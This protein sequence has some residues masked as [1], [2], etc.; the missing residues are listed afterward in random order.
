MPK[1]RKCDLRTRAAILRGSARLLLESIARKKWYTPQP[2]LDPARQEIP[3]PIRR[4]GALS[5]RR[6]AVARAREPQR[7]RRR[8]LSIL[9]LAGLAMPTGGCT[10]FRNDLVTALETATR[11]LA[12][13]VLTSYFDLLREEN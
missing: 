6:D 12:D 10:Q 5:R 13:A 7:Q 11:G 3:R 2:E 1:L 4:A 9:L 8:A